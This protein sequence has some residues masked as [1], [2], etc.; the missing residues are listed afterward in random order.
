MSKPPPGTSGPVDEIH[1]PSLIAALASITAVGI[2]IGLGL[3]LLS[4]IMEKRG[5]APTLNGLNAAMAGLASM[6]AAPFTMKFAHRHGVA[7]TMLLAI[8]FAAASSLGFYY[9]T[10]FWLW[11]P[12]R[13]VFHGAITVL[14]ILS[15]FWINATAPPNRRGFVLGIYGTVLSLGF[16]S[17]PLLFSILGSEGFLPFA[18]GAGVILLSAIPIFLARNESP[19]LDEKPKR[20]FMRYVFLVPTATAA[21]FIFGAVEY[22][23][24]SLFPIF[25]TRAGFSESQAA[26]LLTVMGVGNFI[27]Q[28]PLGMLSDRVKDRRTIL[29]ALTLIGLVGALFLPTLVENWFLMALVLLFWGGCVSG[30]YTVGLSH[31]G[32]RLQ[33]ADLAAANAAFVFSYAVGT[34]AGPQVIGAAMDVT[35]NDGFAWAIAGFFGLYVVLSLV[36]I[37]L[38]PKRP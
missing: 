5:I 9:L 37:V 27:F 28:I 35:G 8:M 11:F 24:L 36:R 32:S 38:K 19:V 25:G 16:A 1:W 15:E 17:G 18:V 30:L 31:L 33:G 20:H 10:N 4:V 22:G 34:V 13:I 29:S 2:A 6:A 7:P 23:G 3:P 12:L 21:V 26:L 14:F